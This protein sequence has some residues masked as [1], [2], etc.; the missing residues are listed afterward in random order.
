[1]NATPSPNEPQAVR[2]GLYEGKGADP[3]K[4]PEYLRH[5]GFPSPLLDWSKSSYIAA[6]F[7]LAEEITSEKV[8]IFAF[9]E[10]P[11]GL[12]GGSSGFPDISVWGEFVASDKRHFLQQCLYS[13]CLKGTQEMAHYKNFGHKEFVSHEEVFKRK[14]P[15]QDLLIKFT[16]PKEARKDALRYLNMFNINH[17][18]LF[19]TEDALVKT[20][21]LREVEELKNNLKVVV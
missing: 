1:M 20:L 11:L 2:V 21:T 5:H 4:L 12:K 10:T 13:M 7:A 17:F 18:S 9:I 15:D 19:Q 14:N 16:L 6:F 3:V 8:A